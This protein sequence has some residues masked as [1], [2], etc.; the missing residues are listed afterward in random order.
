MIARDRSAQ[1][2]KTNAINAIPTPPATPAQYAAVRTPAPALRIKPS[3]TPNTAS[4]GNADM[5]AAG[6]R[7]PSGAVSSA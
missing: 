7:S 5:I 1:N 2:D 4:G 3:V 6:K